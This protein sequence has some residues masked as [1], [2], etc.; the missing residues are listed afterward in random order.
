LNDL[1]E[2]QA[3]LKQLHQEFLDL[4]GK[5]KATSKK[6]SPLLKNCDN[7]LLKTQ[8]HHLWLANGDRNIDLLIRELDK[9]MHKQGE[10]K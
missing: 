5:I 10:E 9:E 1:I 4:T 3:E 7:Y 8:L 2:I 6:L